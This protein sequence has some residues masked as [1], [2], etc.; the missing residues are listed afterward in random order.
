MSSIAATL[1]CTAA[2][3]GPAAAP[4]ELFPDPDL[5]DT[6]DAGLWDY[7]LAGGAWEPGD[8]SG[9]VIT[10][11][12]GSDSV[13]LKGGFL[14]SFNAAVAN[15]STKTVTL[16]FGIWATG[17]VTVVMKGGTP[18]VFAPSDAG[19]LTHSV[20]AGTGSGFQMSGSAEGTTT[21]LSAISVT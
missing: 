18:L 3:C 12:L 10:G 2:I 14:T 15:N 11:A 5:S 8:P 1:P 7:D 16:T 20:T 9:L 17:T 4:S 21:S 19:P 6:S 13:D